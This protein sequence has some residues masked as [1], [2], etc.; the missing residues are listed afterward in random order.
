MVMGRAAEQPEIRMDMTPMIDV[1][2]QLLIFFMCTVR[3][4]ALEGKLSAYLPRDVGVGPTASGAKLEQVD[5]VIKVL[6]E[7]TKL[8]PLTDEPWVSGPFRYGPDRELQY[9]I[10]ALVTQSAS[11]LATRLRLI[12]EAQ[13][14]R[15]L[16]I[17]PRGKPLASTY[18]DMLGV[19]DLAMQTGFTEIRF[20]A[21]RGD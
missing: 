9:Q 1:V 10:G 20:K 21:S 17:D 5:I 4:K 15:A 11:E 13:P 7:G 3:F 6:K 18:A 8:S 16:T 12:H 2:F 19:L 14:D